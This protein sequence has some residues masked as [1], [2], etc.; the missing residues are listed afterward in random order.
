MRASKFA[1]LFVLVPSLVFLSKPPSAQTTSGAPKAM[2]SNEDESSWHGS[3]WTR[4]IETDLVGEKF[5]ELDRMA[6]QLRSEKKRASGGSW[7]LTEFY[8][9]LDKPT[10][11]DKDTLDQVAHLKRWVAQRPDSITPR[12]ALATS[13]HRWAWVARGNGLANTVSDNGWNLFNER[14]Q[15]SLDVL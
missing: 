6:Y 7:K 9:A 11:T 10:L 14:I 13:L 12:V 15:E 4:L 5:D 1:I 8:G 2:A 3:Q